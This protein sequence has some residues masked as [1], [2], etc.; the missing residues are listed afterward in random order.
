ME[1]L[2]NEFAGV[3]CCCLELDKKCR[4]IKSCEFH[5]TLNAHILRLGDPNLLKFFCGDGQLASLNYECFA[6]SL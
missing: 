1:I 4:E 5:Q 6:R 2:E 3:R